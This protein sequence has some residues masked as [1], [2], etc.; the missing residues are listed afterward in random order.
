M[1]NRTLKAL[2][3]IALTVLCAISIAGTAHASPPSASAAPCTPASVDVAVTR[4][5]GFWNSDADVLE[6]SANGEYT[7]WSMGPRGAQSNSQG[8]MTPYQYYCSLPDRF[9]PAWGLSRNAM[10]L[11]DDRSYGADR[12]GLFTCTINYRPYNGEVRVYTR[13][14]G[15]AVRMINAA[16]Q[17]PTPNPPPQPPPPQPKPTPVP[18]PKTGCDKGRDCSWAVNRWMRDLDGL[19]THY[20]TVSFD[21]TYTEQ[22]TVKPQRGT[23]FTPPAAPLKHG[24]WVSNG[25][26]ITFSGLGTANR[27]SRQMYLMRQGL[28][29]TY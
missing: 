16:K 14:S 18:V 19:G 2:S 17:A 13:A 10:C 22:T 20:I 3:A 12:I 23:G 29:K 5:V 8:R 26:D 1:W 7:I 11:H 28:Y 21:G 24:T 6:I 15:A 27:F 4:F 25:T 9:L